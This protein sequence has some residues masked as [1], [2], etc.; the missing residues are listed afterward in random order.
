MANM[1]VVTANEFGDPVLQ[2][3]LMEAGDFSIHVE[4]GDFGQE[5]TR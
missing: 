1:L 5:S 4:R 2:L 3:V